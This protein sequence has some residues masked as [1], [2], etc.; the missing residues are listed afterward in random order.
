[1]G[2][3]IGA[4]E[5]KNVGQVSISAEKDSARFVWKSEVGR[6]ENGQSQ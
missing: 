2:L 6:K 4:P 1:M 3:F 5:R